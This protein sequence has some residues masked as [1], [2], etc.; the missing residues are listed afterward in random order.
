M[1]DGE[2]SDPLDQL[3][4]ELGSLEHRDVAE[5]APVLGRCLDA[6]VAE[7]DELARSIPRADTQGSSP[8]S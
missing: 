6:V 5:H 2:S 1:S 8:L 4:A 7:L 3:E